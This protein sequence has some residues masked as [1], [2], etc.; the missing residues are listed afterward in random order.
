[1]PVPT[2]VAAARTALAARLNVDVAS[3][4][5][6]EAHEAEWSDSCLGLGG[7]AESCLQ[8]ITPGYAV[9]MTYEG[10]GYRYRTNTEGTIVRAE[11]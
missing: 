1:M 4:L 3:I 7:P 2:G 10:T 5:I 9:L 6:L 8:V 11:E